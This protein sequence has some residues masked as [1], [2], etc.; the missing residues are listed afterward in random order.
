MK[1]LISLPLLPLFLFYRWSWSKRA[2]WRHTRVFS[3][4]KN[5]H[6]G[7]K[8]TPRRSRK[9]RVHWA[10][11]SAAS[12]STL[13]L[14]THH[15]NVHGAFPSPRVSLGSKGLPGV[16]GYEGSHGL[17]GDPSND[18][19]DHGDPGAQGL[20]GFKGMPGLIGNRGISGFE[21]MSGKKARK[22]ILEN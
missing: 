15:L 3:T 12:A 4:V 8:R 17:P 11:R 5:R 18:K 2:T 21:G 13:S 6:E 1:C 19:G 16:P 10:K 14:T 7:L 20:P 9:H 22:F